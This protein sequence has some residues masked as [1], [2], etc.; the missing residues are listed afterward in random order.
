ML[1]WWLIQIQTRTRMV[2]IGAETRTTISSFRVTLGPRWNKTTIQMHD[3]V[4]NTMAKNSSTLQTQGNGANEN[5]KTN[6]QT[7]Q[8]QDNRIA[9]AA[10]C[11]LNLPLRPPKLLSTNFLELSRGRSRLCSFP[12]SGHGN[13]ARTFR[14]TETRFI[15]PLVRLLE[16]REPEVIAETAK[17]LNK[18]AGPDNFLH[19]THCKSIINAGGTKHL[20]PLVYFG[21]QMVQIPSFILLCY[22]AM[23][24]PES[25][26]IAQDDVLILLEWSTKQPNLMQDEAIETLVFE[27]K[28]RVEL[29]QSRVSK[30]YH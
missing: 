5:K 10:F 25:E 8:L 2:S 29:Y 4:A 17:A 26:M 11:I 24:I 14:A 12:A 13:L 7:H 22:L 23:H 19:D 3:V 21:E 27:S 1:S 20:V 18:F 28:K 9:L 30:G 15:G 6:H 16:D